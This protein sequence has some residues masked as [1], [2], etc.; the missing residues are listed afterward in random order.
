MERAG[1]PRH[2]WANPRGRESGS[3]RVNGTSD[4][5]GG[6]DHDLGEV[7]NGRAQREAAEIHGG[8]ISLLANHAN[9][10][11]RALTRRTKSYETFPNFSAANSSIVTRLCAD[12]QKLFCG[13]GVCVTVNSTHHRVG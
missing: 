5:A 4:M 13:R 9:K 7:F 3:E 11:F 12:S 1:K 6:W 2:R 10:F 8:L